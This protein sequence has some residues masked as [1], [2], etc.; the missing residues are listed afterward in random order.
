M[1]YAERPY[2]ILDFGRIPRLAAEKASGLVGTEAK[3]KALES[4]APAWRTYEKVYEEKLAEMKRELGAWFRQFDLSTSFT[5]S[6][7]E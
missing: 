5:R 6:A 2:S 4:P 1:Q 3:T 7:I